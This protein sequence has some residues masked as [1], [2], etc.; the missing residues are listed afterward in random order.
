MCIRDRPSAALHALT[1]HWIVAPWESSLGPTERWVRPFYEEE[2][3]PTE[4]A[5]LLFVA[6]KESSQPVAAYLP[7]PAPLAVQ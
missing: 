7:P 2:V 5:Y 3:S 1:G 6:R 4:G